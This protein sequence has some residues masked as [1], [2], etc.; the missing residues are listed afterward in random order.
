MFLKVLPHGSRSAM[1]Q[2]KTGNGSK[3]LAAAAGSRQHPDPVRYYR[4]LTV[5]NGTESED[6]SDWVEGGLKVNLFQPYKLKQS[7]IQM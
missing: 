3:K 1:W 6:S 5:L 7:D 2:Q 4:G